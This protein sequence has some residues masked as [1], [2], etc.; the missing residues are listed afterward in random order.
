MN[1]PA[2][3]PVDLPPSISVFLVRGVLPLS[4]LFQGSGMVTDIEH[5]VHEQSGNVIDNN[6]SALSLRN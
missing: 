5:E 3:Q 2:C 1:V 6:A 4:P